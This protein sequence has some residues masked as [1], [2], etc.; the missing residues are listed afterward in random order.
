[1]YRNGVADLS[2]CPEDIDED[3]LKEAK[4][5]LISGTALAASPSREAALKAVALA[6]K[7]WS[8][9]YL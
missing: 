7:E 1:M 5:I 3:Y 9:H 4:A 8:A 2:L 6:K